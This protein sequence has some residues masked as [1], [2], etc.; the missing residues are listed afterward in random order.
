[1]IQN[2]DQHA[3][4]SIKT[5]KN[6]RVGED[7]KWVSKKPYFMIKIEDLDAEINIKA[8]KNKRGGRKSEIGF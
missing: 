5:E 7:E 1:M 2:E 4:I 6:E 8:G 3:H